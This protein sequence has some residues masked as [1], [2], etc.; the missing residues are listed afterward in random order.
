MRLARED[1]EVQK[2]G[3]L[4]LEKGSKEESS[5]VTSAL[6]CV[7]TSICE[8]VAE[9]VRGVGAW[10]V[11]EGVGAEASAGVELEEAAGAKVGVVADPDAVE[12]VA[13]LVSRSARLA[14][15]DSLPCFPFFP[16]LFGREDRLVLTFLELSLSL[17]V[18]RKVVEAE[19][20]VLEC[21]VDV[22]SAAGAKSAKMLSSTT[23][24]LT[25]S[26]I[27]TDV[28]SEGKR[29]TGGGDGRARGSCRFGRR[30][31]GRA[32]AR[33]GAAEVDVE[34]PRRVT[35]QAKNSGEEKRMVDELCARR[36]RT[37]GARDETL[38]GGWRAKAK[39]GTAE[40]AER[41]LGRKERRSSNILTPYIPSKTSL[42]ICALC[43]GRAAASADFS[44]PSRRW[45]VDGQARMAARVEGQR[46]APSVL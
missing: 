7:S 11:E 42:A 44:Q 17:G 12:L 23:T 34:W 28:S 13:I 29:S 27:S 24:S 31:R 18:M 45:G 10:R 16:L 21:S 22:D 2:R 14:L 6:C 37:E 30:S 20:T 26:T 19:L 9:G 5:P 3:Q 33:M 32:E 41:V 40:V 39:D 15:F 8:G 4:R 35:R 36:C 43:E 1:S 25:G 38:E 46:T